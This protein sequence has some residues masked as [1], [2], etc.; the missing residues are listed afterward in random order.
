MSLSN[1]VTLELYTEQCSDDGSLVAYHVRYLRRDGNGNK[2]VDV[3]LDKY[4]P[5]Y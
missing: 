3:M 5:V 2:A 1:N 4:V